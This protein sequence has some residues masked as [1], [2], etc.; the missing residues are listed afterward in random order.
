MFLYLCIYLLWNHGFLVFKGLSFITLLNYFVLKLSQIWPAEAPLSWFL[1]P[2]NMF[3]NTLLLS[4]IKHSLTF[5]S[6]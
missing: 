5:S 6:S 3:L 1:C 4:A 2:Y